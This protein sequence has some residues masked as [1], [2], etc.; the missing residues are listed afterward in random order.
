MSAQNV[1]NITP[2][3]FAAQMQQAGITSGYVVN[4]NNEVKNSPDSVFTQLAAEM[5]KMED[6]KGHEGV[7]IKHDVDTKCLFMVFVH[8]TVRGQ[9][10]GGTRLKYRDYEMIGGAIKDGLRLSKGMT[11]KNSISRIWWGGGKAIICPLT[12]DQFNV[13]NDHSRDANG[14]KAYTNLDLRT[15]LFKNYGRYVASLGGP[16][17]AAEDMNTVP[18]DMLNILSVCRFVTCLPANVGGSSNP[19]RWT[20]EGVFNAMMATVK[21]HENKDDLTGKTVAIQ[22]VGNVGGPLAHMVL[23]K[24]GSLV[25]F[26]FD[27]ESCKAMKAYRDNKYADNV[28][29]VNSPEELYVADCDIFAPCAIGGILNPTT[30]PNLKCKYVVGAANNQLGNFDEDYKLLRDRGIIYLPDFYINRMGIINCAN[31]QYGRVEETLQNEC[32]KIYDDPRNGTL[33]LL[34]ESEAKNK[35]PHEIA[36]QWATEWGREPHPI[37]GHRGI[38]LIKSYCA[39]HNN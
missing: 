10:Q 36:I 31:E 38:E 4:I 26:D 1:L 29:I 37:W 35:T 22:G 34:K 9:G 17:I 19:S 5:A 25:I 13:I 3:D 16:Y 12:M 18:E 2:E 11:D 8:K 7:F 39:Q 20:A 14:N 33:A 28:K 32:R 27:T 24:G 23:D 15:K 30:I 6:Y 21:H